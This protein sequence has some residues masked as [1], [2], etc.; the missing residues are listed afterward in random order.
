[1]ELKS[2]KM[3]GKEIKGEATLGFESLEDLQ[4]IDILIGVVSSKKKKYQK[5]NNKP[6]DSPFADTPF[7]PEKSKSIVHGI[8]ESK[9]DILD[10]ITTSPNCTMKEIA[11]NCKK[12]V[13]NVSLHLIKLIKNG[14]IKKS[15]S[16]IEGKRKG[17]W[18][19]STC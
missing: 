13:P 3:E 2:I 5:R 16:N 10:Y 11:V 1:M 14:Y 6:V 12:S 19:Y 15:V 17:V 8:S 4:N 18:L 7:E 9:Q